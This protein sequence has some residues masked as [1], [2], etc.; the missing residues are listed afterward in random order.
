VSEPPPVSFRWLGKIALP[1]KDLETDSGSFAA[2]NSLPL[3]VLAQWRWDNEREAVLAQDIERVLA[4]RAAAQ[5]FLV[6]F[7]KKPLT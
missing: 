7:K 6:V 4:E 3:Q 1:K 2:W 5:R